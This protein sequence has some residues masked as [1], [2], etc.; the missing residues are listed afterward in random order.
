[1][2]QSRASYFKWE[3][4]LLSLS[5]PVTSYVFF[6]VFLSKRALHIV[7][8]RATSFKWEYSLLSLSHPVTSY[9]FFLVFLSKRALHIVQSSASSF[10]WEYPFLSLR[11]S[12]NFL[13]L[14]P[15]LLS[16]LSHPFTFPL[17]TSYRMCWR[18]EKDQLDWSCEKWRC[19]T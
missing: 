4:P 1:M 5:H 16:L 18:M 13:R 2:V 8:T 6:L 19:I 14:L 3:Y 17:I 9:V 10:K 11:S 7:Q 12:S 15:H